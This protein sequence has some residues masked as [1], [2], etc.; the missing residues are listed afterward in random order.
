MQ[1]N[2]KNADE[3]LQRDAMHENQ[4]TALQEN[5]QE[6]TNNPSNGDGLI[7]DLAKLARTHNY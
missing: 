4:E 5:L 7:P 3:T 1:G 6:R 2:A